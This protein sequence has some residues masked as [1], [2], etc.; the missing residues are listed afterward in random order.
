MVTEVESHEQRIVDGIDEI[1]MTAKYKSI[2]PINQS[3]V[4]GRNVV[5]LD[6]G[7]GPL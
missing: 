6:S 2:N 7:N 1:V 3:I 5:H 4:N